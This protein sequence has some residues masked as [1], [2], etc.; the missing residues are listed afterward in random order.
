MIVFDTIDLFRGSNQIQEFVGEDAATT[1]ISCYEICLRTCDF[2]IL[3]F[4]SC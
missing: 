1:M 4:S 3:K 2:D